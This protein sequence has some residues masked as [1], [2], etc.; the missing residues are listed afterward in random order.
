MVTE[1]QALQTKHG[2][3]KRKYEARVL[4]AA[5]TNWPALLAAVPQALVIG[6]GQASPE[7]L[8]AAERSRR[9]WA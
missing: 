9:E 4:E 5:S 6:S 7:L 2:I 3:L 1:A 8:A